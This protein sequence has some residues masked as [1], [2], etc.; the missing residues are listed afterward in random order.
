MKCPRCGGERIV[1]S[2]IKRWV[3][4]SGEVKTN[5]RYLCKLCG[6][7]FTQHVRNP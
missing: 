5:Q 4:A 7:V 6:L 3:L 2:G 1:R